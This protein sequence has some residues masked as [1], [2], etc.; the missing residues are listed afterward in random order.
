MEE[1]GK[2]RNKA[3]SRKRTESKEKGIDLTVCN[4]LGFPNCQVI[5][6]MVDKRKGRDY[7][8]LPEGIVPC[9]KKTADR[10]KLLSKL[11]YF[12]YPDCEVIEI[13]VHR[14]KQKGEK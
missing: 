9:E 13:K 14:R 5:K 11:N 12:N 7:L 3:T 10:G 6:Y 8:H 2:G 1:W 4:T